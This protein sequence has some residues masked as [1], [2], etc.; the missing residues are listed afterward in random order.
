MSMLVCLS[1]CLSVREHIS[2]PIFAKVLMHAAPGRS[3][4]LLRTRSDML[5]TSGFMDD[6]MFAHNVP[7]YISTRKGRAFKVTPQVAAP[8]AEAAVYNCFVYVF[9]PVNDIDRHRQN[10]GVSSRVKR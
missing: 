1:V 6:Y 2:R 3:S 7:A 4:V 5:C 9:L 8:G 10:C